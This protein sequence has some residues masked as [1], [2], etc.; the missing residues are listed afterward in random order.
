M[1]KLR[2]IFILSFIFASLI[3]SQSSNEIKKK[4]AELTS[5]RTEIESLKNELNSA[6][7]KQKESLAALEIL[8]KQELLL[9]KLISKLTNEENLIRENIKI[10]NEEIRSAEYRI[11][12]IKDAYS[13]YILWIYK[14]GE[15]KYLE[16]LFS[17][18]SVSQALERYKY[19][20]YITDK[21]QDVISKIKTAKDSLTSYKNEL[22]IEE[23]RK[24]DLL[25][26]K[27]N[28]QASLVKKKE[29]RSKLLTTLRKNQKN[30]E[31]EIKKK[32]AAFESIKGIVERLIKDEEARLSNESKNRVKAPKFNYKKFENFAE[33]KGAVNW[34]VNDATI[35]R[36]FGKNKNKKLNTVTM[37]YGIDLKVGKDQFVRAVVEGVISAIDFIPGYGSVLIITHRD[38]F[39]SVYG[40]ITDL[41]VIEGEIVKSGQVIGSVNE[42][43]EG[44]IFHFEIWKG[45]ENQNPMNWLVKK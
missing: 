12:N 30:I 14:N 44:K 25:L 42:S 38:K 19:L 21:N 15:K 39:R 35:V 32:N 36:F 6:S 40:H 7:T 29:Q 41:K 18:E 9:N 17:S 34:P 37:N 1:E 31:S 24:A 5:L 27:M 45:R 43:L 13:R 10:L 23:K 20:E 8:S 26:T 11:S 33:L 22:Q 2:F 28:D 16:Y 4:K 3:Y